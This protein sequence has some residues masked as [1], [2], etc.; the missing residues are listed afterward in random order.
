[1]SDAFAASVLLKSAVVTGYALLVPILAMHLV[2]LYRLGWRQDPFHV[3]RFCFLLLLAA[4]ICALLYVMAKQVQVVFLFTRAKI[5]HVALHL[6]ARRLV[7]FRWA[8]FLTATVG[9]AS[10]FYWAQFVYLHG[11]VNLETGVCYIYTDS[12]A[13]IIIFAVCDALLCAA[14]LFM[15]VLPLNAHTKTMFRQSKLTGSPYHDS[16]GDIRHTAIKNLIRSSWSIMIGLASLITFAAIL[17]TTE[18][19][20]PTQDALF[21]WALCAPAIEATVGLVLIHSLTTVWIPFRTTHS[22]TSAQEQ[23]KLQ[24]YPSPRLPPGSIPATTEMDK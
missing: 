7:Q 13:E 14:M 20:N 8:V 18:V 2:A 1:M 6:H 12:P 10:L 21:I 3:R 24:S 15:F 9:V 5:V 16:S 19:G 17:A 22:K 11:A 4:L 23:S